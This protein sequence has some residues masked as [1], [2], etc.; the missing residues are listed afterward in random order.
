MFNFFSFGNPFFTSDLHYQGVT[1]RKTFSSRENLSL[2]RAIAAYN[3][4][5]PIKKLLH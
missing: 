1:M 5:P 4:A 2:N 3:A